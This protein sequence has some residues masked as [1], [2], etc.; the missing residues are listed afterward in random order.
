MAFEVYGQIK[1]QNMKYTPIPHSSHEHQ[2]GLLL[3]FGARFRMSLQSAAPSRCP[4]RKGGRSK[5]G[6]SN[7]VRLHRGRRLALINFGPSGWKRRNEKIIYHFMVLRPGL[8]TVLGVLN[9]RYQSTPR[10][11]PGVGIARLWIRN[12]KY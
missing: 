3:T 8:R 7:G 1:S 9:C 5:K 11:Q 4:V 2:Y 10:L 6:H 12:N